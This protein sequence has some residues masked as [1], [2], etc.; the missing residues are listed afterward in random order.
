MSLDQ[1]TLYI[2]EW[3]KRRISIFERL[4]NGELKKQKS[5]AM[6]TPVDNLDTGPDGSIWYAG[7]PM[8]FEFLAHA[9]SP[10]T[11]ATSVGVK[12]DPDSGDYEIAFVSTGG[13]ING[14]SVMAAAGDKLVIGA[15]FDSHVLVCPNP[16]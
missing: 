5:I 1:S 9:E 15:V 6:P 11:N 16:S 7:Q 2:A 4:A 3:S 14:A 10:E 13:E 8:I 12:L